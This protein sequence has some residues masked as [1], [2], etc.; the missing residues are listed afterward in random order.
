MY[1]LEVE[2]TTSQS[3]VQRPNHYTTERI[4]AEISF[5][6]MTVYDVPYLKTK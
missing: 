5:A 4:K 1:W 6:C 2:L 3:Q